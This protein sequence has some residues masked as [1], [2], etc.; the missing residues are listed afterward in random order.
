MVEHKKRA[1][2]QRKIA[3]NR[4]RRT[5]MSEE[6]LRKYH[7]FFN[8]GWKLFRKYSDLTGGDDY[9]KHVLDDANVLRTEAGKLNTPF[10]RD[11]CQAV[12]NGLRDEVLK[13]KEEKEQ[14]GTQMDLFSPGVMP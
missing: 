4:E 7:Y 12:F 11:L 10:A 6:Q 8:E 9:W 2:K 1:R 3:Q 5:I 13:L 14:E